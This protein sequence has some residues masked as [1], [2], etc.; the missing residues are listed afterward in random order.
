MIELAEDKEEPVSEAAATRLAKQMGALGYVES[1]ALTQRN[2]KEVFD[3][4]LLSALEA[5][6]RGVL[7]DN[8]RDHNHSNN[9]N[10]KRRRKRM[11]VSCVGDTCSVEDY[12]V[13]SEEQLRDGRKSAWRKLCCFI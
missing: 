9:N 7:L 11:G 12:S 4:A 2:L 13:D 3:Q 10:K 6:S 5:R 1:S 8:T